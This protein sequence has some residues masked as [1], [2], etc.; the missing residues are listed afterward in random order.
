LKTEFIQIAPDLEL[1]IERRG[2]GPAL[3]ML[4]GEEAI[5]REAPFL[6]ELARD[7]EVIIPSPPGFGRSTRPDW[8]TCPDDIAY[9]YLDAAER[10]GLRAVPVVGFSL[11]G[12][13]AAE[14]ATKD[15]GFISRL[16]LVDA[17]G[18]KTGKPTDRDIQDIWLLHPDE[19]AALK[20]FDPANGARDYKNMPEEALTVI[21]R[22][23]ESFAR[24]CWD[25]YMH[26]PKLRHRLH[27]INVPTLL[28]W[29]ER[30]G[31]VTPAYGEAYRKLIPDA[32]MV[33][34]ARAGH[35]PHIEQPA[36]FLGRLREFLA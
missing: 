7:Y 30:D 24:F 28:V 19:V 31:I 13:I 16:V 32:R 6:D 17:Y 33:V 22:N 34:I 9:I 1:E 29:G 36:A 15:H 8:I 14:M 35:L 20:W 25:P 26:N 4:Y 3:L 2:R 5:E 23:S 12:W 18:I 21:A 10:L 27:R 11:G